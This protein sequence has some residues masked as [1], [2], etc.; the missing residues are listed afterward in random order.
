MSVCSFISIQLYV[1]ARQE[2]RPL[3]FL[4]WLPQ[5]LIQFLLLGLTKSSHPPHSPE[6]TDANCMVKNRG[7]G[8]QKRKW[9]FADAVIVGTKQI[10][11][12]RTQEGKC[13]INWE[14]S[15]IVSEGCMVVS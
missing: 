6:H 15:D 1:P 11:S 5:S 3:R 4:Q 7:Q 2:K 13:G 12:D 14:E 9:A 8:N 10:F